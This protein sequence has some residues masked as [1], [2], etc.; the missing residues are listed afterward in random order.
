MLSSHQDNVQSS[1]GGAC[2]CVKI[3][4][5]QFDIGVRRINYSVTFCQVFDSAGWINVVLDPERHRMFPGTTSVWT[6]ING[7]VRRQMSP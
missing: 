3:W 2:R 1:T 7:R 4:L 6:I 5:Q